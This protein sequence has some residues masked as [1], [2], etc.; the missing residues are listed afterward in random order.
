MD[1]VRVIE[2]FLSGARIGRIALTPKKLHA[3]LN[4]TCHI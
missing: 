1:E 3:L 2:V 4:M